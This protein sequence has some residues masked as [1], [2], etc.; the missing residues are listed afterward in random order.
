MLQATGANRPLNLIATKQN[1][2][3]TVHH[4][5]SPAVPMLDSTGTKHINIQDFNF[6]SLKTFKSSYTVYIYK[7]YSLNIQ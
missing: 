3:P 5:T 4:M 1:E 7:L 6:L 2:C